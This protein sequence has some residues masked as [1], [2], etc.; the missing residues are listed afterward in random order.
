MG[1]EDK[2]FEASQQ[3]LERV[4]K[5]GQVI[6]S[7]DFSIAVSMLVMFIAIHKLAPFIWDQVSMLFV[8]IYEQIPNRSVESVGLSYLLF[9]TLVPMVLIIAP[10]LLLAFCVAVIADLMQVGPLIATKAIEPKLDKLNP[11][12]GF[13][14]I[15]SVKTVFELF[16]NIVKVTLLGIVAYVVFTA[17]IPS[18]L[19][20]CAMENS[21]SIINELGTLIVEFVIKAGMLFLV[22]A[23]ADYGFTRWKFLKDQKMS[24][25]EVK[26]E[27]KN[28]E[29]DPH[30]KSQLRQ[31]RMQ[32]AQQSMLNAV[33]DADFVV[34]NPVH[35]SVAIKY[36]KEE[37]EAPKL[38]AKGTE[39]FAKKI[40]KVAKENNIPV[41]ENPPV[42]RALFRLVEVD[43]DIPPELYKAVAEILMFVYNLH[44]DK[45]IN[46]S[47][48]V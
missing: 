16:K 11:V 45:N 29:G 25:K 8:L 24:F 13:K 7:K 23:G 14:N 3:K 39:L 10:I 43:S 30:V 44:K 33:P 19:S 46:S 48:L 21:F 20:L 28:S 12:K 32:M 47:K 2:Q 1:D 41:V 26:D 36:N 40:V 15:F 9:L 6:K 37:M 4:R 17:H 27:H 42:A 5:E 22:I 18:V 31:R 35:V 38:I 34:T